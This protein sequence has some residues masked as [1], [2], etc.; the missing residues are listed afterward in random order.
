MSVKYVKL[1]KI[2]FTTVTT[3]FTAAENNLRQVFTQGN[4]KNGAASGSGLEQT[5]GIQSG[6]LYTVILLFLKKNS[7]I[8][9]ANNV[10]KLVFVLRLNI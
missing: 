5:Y 4:S 6:E 10:Q 8:S 3:S 7:L 1:N 9:N 2:L